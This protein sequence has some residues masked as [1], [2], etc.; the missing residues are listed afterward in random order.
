MILERLRRLFFSGDS[1][2]ANNRFT[3]AR[4]AASSVVVALQHHRKVDSPEPHL[5]AFDGLLTRDQLAARL[6]LSPRQMTWW[7]WSL[8]ESRRYREFEIARRSGDRPRLIQ[9]PIKPIR[10][11]QDI[12]LPMFADAYMPWPHVHGFVYGRSAVTNAA[13]HRGQRWILR[14][15]LRDFFPSINFGRVRGMLQASPFEL[16][17]DVATAVAQI[18][19]HRGALPQ[20]APT[21]PVISNLI[22]RGLDIRLARF[23]KTAHCS[24]SRYA[25]DICFST[26][27]K[28]FPRQL[29]ELT[30]GQAEL[31]P[32]LRS[33]VEH[34]G[35]LIN[36]SKTRLMPRQQRQRVTG[37]IVNKK[38][39]VPREY[40]R[41]LRAVV[42]IWQKYGRPDA[43]EA[44]RRK[45]PLKNWP[46]GKAVPDFRLVVR[47]QVQYLGFVRNY[48]FVYQQIARVLADCDPTFTPMLPRVPKRGQ[49]TVLG[50]GPSD[51]IQFK[52]AHRALHDDFEWLDMVQL[53]HKPP[54]G[55]DQLWNWLHER[56]T[57][58]NDHPIVGIFDSDSD[59]VPAIA[60]I[61][62]SESVGW[63]HLGNGVIAMNI[64]PPP[65]MNATD[66][67]CVE[68][69]HRPETL[70]R[71]TD[72]GRRVFL[73]SEFNDKGQSEDGQYKM[74]YPAKGT[75]IV[76]KVERI[77]DGA[78]VVLSK[79][80]F[81]TKVSSAVKPY[82]SV[83]FGGFRPTLE[84][85][86]NAVAVAQTACS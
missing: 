60:R 56:K 26:G 46:P 66:P 48:D 59:Y 79:F 43:E 76:E 13:V 45:F 85:L 78:S 11:M 50:E 12:L 33:I 2:R 27:M 82:E 4:G 15:D 31:N 73:R 10:D 24:Y 35:F 58:H 8:R 49:V 86:S 5:T 9:T 25:D 29:A 84:R 77:D 21:S 42:Y 74:L 18:C 22:C 28:V 81:A 80:D 47:G 14:I 32:K 52:A 38:L 36:D 7:I 69:L 63:A 34:E 3:L 51:I 41:H 68:M 64:A 61:A 40:R 55:E 20:G 75:L 70:C 19:C 37:I 54:K 30:G 71:M 62:A 67:F 23:A 39:N 44:F 65:W 83:D 17:A 1:P 72:E 57:S 16:P 6:G 53:D